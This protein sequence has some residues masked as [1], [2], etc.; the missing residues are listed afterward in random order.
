MLLLG[1]VTAVA[2]AALALLVPRTGHA[3]CRTTTTPIPATYSPTTKGCFTAGLPLF[4]KGACVG[5]SVNQAAY[6]IAK[7]FALRNHS[8]ERMIVDLGDLDASLSVIPM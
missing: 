6:R 4:W 1:R 5:Y 3:F 7:P 8:S 2:L